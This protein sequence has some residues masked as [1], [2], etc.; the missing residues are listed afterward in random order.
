MITKVAALLAARLLEMAASEFGNHGCNDMDMATFDGMTLEEKG[1]LM[2]QFHIWDQEANPVDWEP[3]QFRMIGDTEW[4]HFCA[5][6]L[7][8]VE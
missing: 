4:M 5:D 2:A 1:W 8:G 6:M 7:R 3:R